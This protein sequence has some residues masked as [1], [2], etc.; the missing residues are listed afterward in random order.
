MVEYH[1]FLY[2]ISDCPFCVKAKQLLNDMD[3]LY[4]YT[5]ID[6]D[7]KT[8]FLNKMAL[9][10]NNQRTFPLVFHNDKFIGG[11]TQLDDYLAFN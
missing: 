11:F 10:T 8:F 9:K 4:V 6:K 5:E 2:G 7:N 3:I 1:Y